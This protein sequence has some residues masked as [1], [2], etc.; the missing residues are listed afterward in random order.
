MTFLAPILAG[1]TSLFSGG[2]LAA[3]GTGLSL[4]TTVGGLIAQQGIAKQQAQIA[5]QNAKN[6]INIAQQDQLDQGNLTAA[7]IGEQLALAGSS[8]LNVDSRSFQLAR[9]DTARFGRQDEL[10]ARHRGEVEAFNFRTQADSIRSQASSDLLTGIGGSLS[11]FLRRRPSLIGG[12]RATRFRP[13]P[14]SR[15]RSLVS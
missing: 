3:I 14:V 4:V 15:P 5:E 9:K 10:R 7:A 13:V 1:A 11:S 8:G 6:A 12:S 2:G